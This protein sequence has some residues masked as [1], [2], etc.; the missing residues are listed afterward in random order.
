MAK[1]RN[2]GPVSSR[3]LAS[4]EVHDVEE[5]RELGVVNAYRLL[6]LRGHPV[7]LNL[8]WAMEAALRDV[9]WMEITPEDKDH[10]RAEL[11]APW[12]PTELLGL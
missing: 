10:L 1:I 2:L 3:W 7:S 4:I 9:H 8:L 5:L 12:D 6:A 11:A